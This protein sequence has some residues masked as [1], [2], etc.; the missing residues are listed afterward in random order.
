MGRSQDAMSAELPLH[1]SPE[2][3]PLCTGDGG[4]SDQARLLA[5]VRA[6]QLQLVSQLASCR[7][8]DINHFYDYPDNCTCLQ[9]AIEGGRHD[10]VAEL[11]RCRADPNVWNPVLKTSLLHLAV[12]KRDPQ[13]AVLLLDHG[14]DVATKNGK[15]RTPLHVL[16]ERP[17][18]DDAEAERC[19]ALGKALLARPTVDVDAAD[20][21]GCTAL[22]LAAASGADQVAR[23]LLSNNADPSCTVDGCSAGELLQ[24]RG[25]SLE[26]DPQLAVTALTGRSAQNVLFEAL[27]QR[28]LTRFGAVLR[29]NSRNRRVVDAFHGNTTCLQYASDHGLHEYVGLLLRHG[30]DVSLANPTNGW[31]ALH[32]AAARGF[33]RVLEKLIHHE[34]PPVDVPDH[35]GET[36]LHKLARAE[37][38]PQETDL[39]EGEADRGLCLELLTKMQAAQPGR[40]QLDVNGQDKLGSTPLH[41]AVARGDAVAIE[42]LLRLGANIGV[43]N[44]FGE[45]PVRGLP[46]DALQRYLDECVTCNDRPV[47]DAHF[48]IE[49]CYS[50]LA[51]RRRG[52]VDPL[53]E[54]ESLWYM[55]QSKRHRH[56]L[57]HPVISSFLDLKWQVV[58]GSVWANLALYSLF[59]ILMTTFVFLNVS[60]DWNTRQRRQATEN[61][62]SSNSQ[63]VEESSSDPG[64]QFVFIATALILVLLIL[65]ELFQFFVA[66]RR[67]IFSF[68]NYVEASM[69]V[70]SALLLFSTVDEEQTRRFSALVIL[71]SWTEFFM[72]MG[73]LPLFSIYVTMFTTVLFR[74]VRF[75]A[76][77]FVLIVAFSLSMFVLFQ[78]DEAFP[79]PSSALI[80]TMVM[81][82]GEMDY[83]S[84]P[85]AQ[86]TPVAQLVFVAFLFLITVVLMNLLNGLA[87]ADT[88]EIQDQA[89]IY[90]Y[91]GRVEL[92]S[93]IESM[94]LGDPFNFLSNYPPFKWLRWVP[95]CAPCSWLG[96][97]SPLTQ[98]RAWLGGRTLLFFN[99]L[100]NKNLTVLPNQRNWQ[101]DPNTCNA[102]FSLDKQ[103][104]EDAK[105]LLISKRQPQDDVSERLEQLEKKLD[106]LLS[107][108]LPAEDAVA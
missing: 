44:R 106:R 9:A 4:A 92:I 86:H 51:P 22:Y 90:G 11:L 34:P 100:P 30:A 79:N 108:L 24:K 99:T 23:L 101:L 47:T 27:Q 66:P 32:F 62:N 15:G 60:R 98:L 77:Y 38:D 28:D 56:L 6:G 93:Y 72:L 7:D 102:R 65:R 89:Q 16:A 82:I 41:Y 25:V 95:D 26:P 58:R 87:V 35:G 48:Q 36:V 104:I 1:V 17:A 5:A 43:K 3:T 40:L 53:P 20:R 88:G 97:V 2:S 80:K 50:F 54:T 73:R 19:V 8:V 68:E 46:A 18:A 94:L 12:Q 31:T 69:L 57:K 91:V 81:T 52:F 83:G 107:R 45:T 63:T 96:S 67:Y 13:C 64:F 55:A 71:L 76:W 84:L 39:A 10:I 61:P 21:A 14:A 59:V 85:I 74:F 75:L 105:T 29:D 70:L 49:L 33:H 37:Y 42:A 78:G 103:I